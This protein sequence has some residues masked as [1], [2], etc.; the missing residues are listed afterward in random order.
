MVTP[1][2]LA[3]C[4]DPDPAVIW[5][6][7][8]LI[9]NSRGRST[10]ISLQRRLHRLRLERDET[11]T[12]YIARARHIEFLLSEVGI[13][14]TDEELILA[15]TAGL[16]HSYD[17]FL[18]TLDATADDQYTL[19]N[20]TMR[21]VNEYQRQNMRVYP[22]RPA[23]AT[24]NPASRDEAMSVT[25]NTQSRL[26]RITCFTCGN[27]GHYQ[28]NCPT[29]STTSTPAP[30]SKSSTPDSANIVDD[31]SDDDEDPIF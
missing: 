17:P 15:I 18:V 13:Y 22:S 25:Q 7:L 27:K 11:M 28:V 29:R 30:H 24:T 10:V 31:Y 19:P 8:D 20:I 12:A 26:A 23:P 1:S 14:V 4:R 16:P 9:H 3:H 6:N 5:A 21:L 2:Q